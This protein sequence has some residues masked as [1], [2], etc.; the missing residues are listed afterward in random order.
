MERPFIDF[1]EVAYLNLDLVNFTKFCSVNNVETIMELLG[2][3]YSK[4]G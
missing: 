1:G 4:F 3:L 2:N